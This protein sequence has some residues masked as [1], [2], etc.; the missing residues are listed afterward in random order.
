L[1]IKSYIYG[2]KKK[3]LLKI[4]YYNTLFYQKSWITK[5][6]KADKL[7]SNSWTPSENLGNYQKIKDEL[8]IKNI[9][10]KR[11]LEIGCLDG[12]WSRCIIDNAKE[13]TLCDLSSDLIPLLESKFGKNKFKFYETKGYELEGIPSHSIDFIFSIDTFPRVSKRFLKNYFKDFRRILVPDGQI[14]I[15]L[16]LYS[17]ELSQSKNFVS[18]Y[19]KE[20]IYFLEENNFYNYHIDTKTVKHGCLLMVNI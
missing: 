20:I 7:N 19:R 8:L 9:K 3:F 15:H 12:R 6:I 5:A 13:V 4:G 14:L 16:P 1:T 11:V 10:N 2:F 17:S 18:L